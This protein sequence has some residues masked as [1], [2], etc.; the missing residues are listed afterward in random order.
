V[1]SYSRLVEKAAQAAFFIGGQGEFSGH[2]GRK[3]ALTPVFT[4][5]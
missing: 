4:S 1:T 2:I 3:C 5:A